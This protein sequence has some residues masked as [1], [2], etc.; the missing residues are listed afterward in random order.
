MTDTEDKVVIPEKSDRSLTWLAL[1]T[2]AA[3]AIVVMLFVAG[4][5]TAQVAKAIGASECT[6]AGKLGN[7]LTG[8]SEPLYDC[9]IIGKRICVTYAD[10]VGQDVTWIASIAFAST[11]G[12]EKP[13]CAK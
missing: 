2:V 10:G 9:L 7:R 8:S 5:S 12:V 13:E 11:L 6:V 3:V 4:P 1:V